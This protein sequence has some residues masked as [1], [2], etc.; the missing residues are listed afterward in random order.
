MSQTAQWPYTSVNGAFT[1][2]G[3]STALKTTAI[4]V[5]DVAQKVPATALVGRNSMSLRVIGTNDVYFGASNVTS[6]N[7]YLKKQYEEIALDITD[8]NAVA[9]WAVCATGLTSQI[10]ILEV[11]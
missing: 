7:G 9:V 8:N 5:T 10:R 4:T 6:S 11:A 2:K 3:L 1:T